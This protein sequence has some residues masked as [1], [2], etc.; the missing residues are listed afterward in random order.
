MADQI[1][2]ILKRGEIGLT[3]IQKKNLRGLGLR[4]RHSVVVREDTSDIRGMIKKVIH[5]VEVT[6]AIGPIKTNPKAVDYEI[7]HVAKSE[8]SA[9]AP[10]APRKSSKKASP[11]KEKK[12]QTKK[13]M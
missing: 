5:L 2:I 3:E 7:T 9:D 11:A 6:K 10:S 12:T 4:K 13:G 1:Q 8:S